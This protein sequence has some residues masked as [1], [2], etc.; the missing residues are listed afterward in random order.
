MNETHTNLFQQ[1]YNEIKSDSTIDSWL[2][3]SSL[4]PLCI[5]LTLYLT[6]VLKIGPKIMENREP[7]N[8]KYI[9]LFYNLMQT[10]FNSYIL[11]YQFIKPEVSSYVWN[12]AC[13]PDTTKRNI[14]IELH[15]VSWYFAISKIIDLLDTVFFVLKKKKSH[16]S[17][18]HVY[19]HVN[20]VITCFGQL[21]FIKSE[22]VAIGIILNSFVHV[23]MYSYYFL[24]ALGPNMQ[25]H[26]WWKKYLTCIQIIQFILGILY[27][28]SL[29][30]FK[31]TYS[32]LFIVYM[33]VDVI[34]F[35][36]LFLKFYKKT[37]KIKSKIQ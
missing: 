36:Y 27:C 35:L 34:I 3:V 7:I 11:V 14:I 12:H 30:V 21:R 18:L 24:A 32:K 6:F 25:K 4:W 20:M 33:L 29:I 15:I 2:F 1:L 28:V 5:I 17:F 8:I 19:H 10:I 26:L 22:N 13:H 16:I 31:C 9:I 23:V 37:Y